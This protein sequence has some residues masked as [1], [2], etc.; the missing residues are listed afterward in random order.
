MF[1]GNGLW[2]ALLAGFMPPAASDTLRLTIHEVRSL[3]GRQNLRLKATRLDADIARGELRQAARLRFNPELALVVPGS[4]AGGEA[5][6]RELTLTQELEW[7]GQRGARAGAARYRLAVA[8][9]DVRDAGRLTVAEASVTF[10]RAL[11]AER[12]LGVA[13]ELFTLAERLAAAVRIQLREGEISALEANLAEIELGRAQARVGSGRRILTSALLELRWTAGLPT[14]I[15]LAL[16]E[17]GT[18]AAPDPLRLGLDTLTQMALIRRP[19][20]AVANATVGEAEG[21]A[22][23]ARRE[24]L[25]NLRVGAVAEREQAGGQT[26]VGFTVGLGVPLFNRNQGLSAARRA[27]T[28]QAGL[29]R[30]ATEQRIRVE[31]LD[32]VR[33]YQ[34]AVTEAATLDS[35]VRQPARRNAS[36]LEAAYRA[37][38]IALPSLLLLRNQLLDAELGYWDAWFIERE[39]LIRVESVTG[40][41]TADGIGSGPVPN[42][43]PQ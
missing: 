32:A 21:L 36:L 31:V 24:G 40:S 43:R 5:S 3:V 6:P 29:E 10:L 42:G 37:G 20:L 8:E 39:A 11:A 38:K 26:R 34:A 23:L 30:R 27:R 16:V 15:P 33:G 13:E 17:D 1:V 22:K 7:G 9:A 41:L 12:R 2:I 25:P 18:A 19:D 14:D 28:E 4:A 35:L